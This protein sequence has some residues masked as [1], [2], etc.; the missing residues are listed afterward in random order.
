MGKQGKFFVLAVACLFA[1][2]APAMAATV[3]PGQGSGNVILL[4]LDGVRWQEVFRT[5]KTGLLFKHLFQEHLA[6]G[7]IFGNVDKDAAMT[8]SNSALLSLPAYQSI[9]SGETQPCSGNGC[10]RLGVETFQERAVSELK[11]NR[12]KVATIASWDKIPDAVEHVEGA[13]FVN[14]AYDKLNDGTYDPEFEAI[15]EAQVKDPAPWDGARFDRYTWAH[16]MHYLKKHHP[17]FLFISLDDSDEWGHKNE[18]DNY[19][20]SLRQYD[21]WIHELI[22]TLQ[23]MGEYG[24]NTTLLVTT[25][26]GR[27]DGEMWGQHGWLW[28]ECK[29]VWLYGRPARV[30]STFNT[31][32]IVDDETS[33]AKYSH[34]DIRPTIEVGL[35]LTPHTCDGCGKV[36]PGIVPAQLGSSQSPRLPSGTL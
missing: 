17:R 31:S 1:L 35:G 30:N 5:D 29:Y 13:T 20:A 7:Q 33:E 36:M 16:S 3:K 34:I 24:A 18:W 28:P 19:L 27:G 15:N 12:L 11:L 23:G 32:T 22:Q 4:M 10:G 9:M 26:H 25:D 21:N 6:E 8:V 2:V 14:A